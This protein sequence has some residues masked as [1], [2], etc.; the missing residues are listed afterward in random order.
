LATK[1]RRRPR[2]RPQASQ[3]AKRSSQT[4]GAKTSPT[5]STKGS[6]AK[7]AARPKTA[8]R[9]PGA[10]ADRR[11][12]PWVRVAAIAAVI[13]LGWLLLYRTNP[14]GEISAEARSAARAAGAP[15][16]SGR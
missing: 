2:S 14:P 11:T 16:S 1:R 12:S 7:T 8:K 9:R 6:A 4:S 3:A 5:S 10:T 13:A 15:T